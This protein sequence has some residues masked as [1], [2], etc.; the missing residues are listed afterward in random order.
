MCLPEC[1]CKP[2]IHCLLGLSVTMCISKH[3]PVC[4]CVC[5]ECNECV[6]ACVYV[7]LV[8]LKF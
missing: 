5:L 2:V 8:G 7:H 3:L 1:E 6:N 4:L